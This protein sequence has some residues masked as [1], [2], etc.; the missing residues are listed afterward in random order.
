MHITNLCWELHSIGVVSSIF[1]ARLKDVCVLASIDRRTSWN[2]LD[3]M[4]ANI[5]D[6]SMWATQSPVKQWGIQVKHLKLDWDKCENLRGK[7][8]K[9][10][11][12]KYIKVWKLQTFPA[13]HE[14]M[15]NYCKCL[16]FPDLHTALSGPPESW[17]WIDVPPSHGSFS[18]NTSNGRGGFEQ[19]CCWHQ[20]K[21]S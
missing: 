5:I 9:W 16:C 21:I 10:D 19:P 14:N 7:C 1:S 11:K 15:S 3:R 8:K 12:V 18:N 4:P 13:T 2:S 17:C 6:L 20:D